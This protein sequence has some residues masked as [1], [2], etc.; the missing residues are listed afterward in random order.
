MVEN[1][2]S[3]FGI[4]AIII[5]ASGLG[6]GAFTVV[7]FQILEGPQG[8]PGQDG[9]D[10]VGLQVGI[11][12]PDHY[13]IVSGLLVVRIL[14]W[15]SSKCSIK[16]FI[17]GSLNT[18]TI[19]WEWDTTIVSDGWYN[20]SV[21]IMDTES[22][23]AKDEVMVYVL[24]NPIPTPRARVWRFSTYLLTGGPQRINFD[25]KSYD[26]TGSFNLTTDRYVIPENGY[27]L[28]IASSLLRIHGY[29]IGEIAICSN[30]YPNGFS[31]I[32]STPDTVINA[33]FTVSI[34]DIAY[35]SEGDWI[36]ITLWLVVGPPADVMGE[37]GDYRSTFFSITKLSN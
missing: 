12:D 30:D 13:E 34:T 21:R 26:S 35:F 10:I 31:R 32:R 17:N 16:V 11:L 36:E 22:N 27:Y 9:Q 29:T 19:P 8:L 33:Q 23:I 7:N 24:N 3:L 5:G 6:L 15:N 20:I 4:I 25:T 1:K 2:S 37:S 18:N 14:I 28:L